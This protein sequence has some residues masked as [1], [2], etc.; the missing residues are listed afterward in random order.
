MLQLREGN[1][2]YKDTQLLAMPNVKLLFTSNSYGVTKWL[3]TELQGDLL[4]LQR[5]YTDLSKL[6][7]PPFCC[8]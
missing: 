3:D 8:I 2:L 5:I 1:L 7:L 4:I 6:P